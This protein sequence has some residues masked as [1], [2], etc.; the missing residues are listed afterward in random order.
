MKF[1]RFIYFSCTQFIS[2]TLQIQITSND[3]LCHSF[4]TGVIRIDANFLSSLHKVSSKLFS[5]VI[6]CILPFWLLIVRSLCCSSVPGFNPLISI[7]ATPS[8][9]GLVYS[10][11]ISPGRTNRD[12]ARNSLR[13]PTLMWMFC[14]CST[15]GVIISFPLIQKIIKIFLL[16][17]SYVRHDRRA[18]LNFF[19]Y[20]YSLSLQWW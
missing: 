12:V 14:S 18:A 7:H 4:V 1:N 5:D 15:L 16:W 9:R 2:D 11:F 20:S 3:I 8:A 13:P 6:R 10:Y 17:Y 19:L